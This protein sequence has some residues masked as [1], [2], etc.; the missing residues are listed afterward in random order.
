MVTPDLKLYVPDVE[1]SLSNA[2]VSGST[3]LGASEGFTVDKV[4]NKTVCC[5]KRFPIKFSG[6]GIPISFNLWI[7]S[8]IPS[9]STSVST[10]ILLI[11]SLPSLVF[12]FCVRAPIG[13]HRNF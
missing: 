7:P 6:S 1:A 4:L 9:S 13:A 3:A 8:A 5:A 11:T 10:V 12:D 2:P